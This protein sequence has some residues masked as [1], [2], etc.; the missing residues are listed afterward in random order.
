MD[1]FAALAMTIDCFVAP[2]LAM[3]AKPCA[4]LSDK[5]CALVR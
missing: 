2:L 5:R 1:C 3:T 4:R